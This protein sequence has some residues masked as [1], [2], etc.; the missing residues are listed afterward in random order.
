[1]IKTK[2][3]MA[4]QIDPESIQVVKFE[5]TRKKLPP[6]K[7]P[8][9]ENKSE[10]EDSEFERVFGDGPKKKKSQRKAKLSPRFNQ[11]E[12]KSLTL[13]SQDHLRLKKLIL[14]SS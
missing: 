10:S 14:T 1:M 12:E 8:H 7:P 2:A 9:A 6:T 11:Q 4:K 3:S 13:E 5:G